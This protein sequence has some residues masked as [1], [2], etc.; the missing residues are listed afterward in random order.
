VTPRGFRRGAS[1]IAQ[2]SRSQPVSRVLL[3]RVLRARYDRHSSRRRVAAALEPPTRGLGEQPALTLAS[4][5]L[6]LLRMEVAAFH[7]HPLDRMR[8]V[9]VALFL[10]FTAARADSLQRLGVTQHPALRSPDFP[11]PAT[12][13]VRSAATVWLTSRANDSTS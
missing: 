12:L 10:A 3:R 11:L 9:S 8:L 7:P 2:S 6:V 4:A 1:S 13:D 5:Y